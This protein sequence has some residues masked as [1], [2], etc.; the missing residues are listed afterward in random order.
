MRKVHDI[1]ANKDEGINQ[2]IHHLILQKDNVPKNKQKS[3]RDILSNVVTES[4]DTVV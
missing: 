3:V 1:I 2:I 4:Q